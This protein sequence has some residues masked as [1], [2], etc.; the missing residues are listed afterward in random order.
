MATHCVVFDVVP[1]AVEDLEKDGATG[2][3]SVADLV[4]KL[5]RRARSG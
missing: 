3:N 2:A 1:E 5:A 4:E